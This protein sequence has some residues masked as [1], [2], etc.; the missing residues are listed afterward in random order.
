[1][2][3][4]KN[5]FCLYLL[6]SSLTALGTSG[7]R[8]EHSYPVGEIEAKD[9]NL[10]KLSARDYKSVE[11][12]RS[13]KFFMINGELEKAKLLLKEAPLVTNFSKKAQLRY[14]AMIHFIEGNYVESTK[15]LKRSDMQDSVIKGRY[16]VM[17]LISMLI[18]NQKELLKSE[19]KSCRESVSTKAASSLVWLDTIIKLKTQGKSL[20]SE[21][22]FKDLFIENLDEDQLRVYLKLAIYLNQQDKIIPKF[23]L[24]NSDTLSDPLFREL[25][26]MNYFRNL[27]LVKA[28]QFLENSN[29]PNA[30]VFKGN[31]L[32]L[33][34]KYE[35]AYAQYKLALKQKENSAN[36]L[37]RI[38]PLAWKLGQWQ[39]GIDFIKRFKFH[40]SDELKKLT[41]L[42]AFQT[43][44]KKPKKAQ[45]TIRY[46]NKSTQVGN[47]VEVLQLKTLNSL[48]LEDE[49]NLENLAYETCIRKDGLHC[50]LLYVISAW[51]EPSKIL[52]QKGFIHKGSL[53]DY[54][55]DFQSVTN[56]PLKE[57]VFVD[58][59]DI[60]EL[61]NELIELL[62]LGS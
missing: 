12:I 48:V 50:W 8:F 23:K 56:N 2:H 3:Y 58:Q 57:E 15:I 37:E 5:I 40:K 34:N 41:L 30:E 36:A 59:K 38:I 18:L 31:I 61:D 35:A 6:L 20:N 49:R 39:E 13:A 4:L 7:V 21:D 32:L 43:M 42:A 10:A 53:S 62:T 16:C 27:D 26:G 60:E 47:P 25:I 11:L 28:Y 51:D 22:I 52:K 1:M 24:L 55:S 54:K 17:N 44:Q 33:Q 45:R 46:I 19:Y 14:L 29:D 9:N